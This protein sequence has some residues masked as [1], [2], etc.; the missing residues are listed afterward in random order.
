M[1]FCMDSISFFICTGVSSPFDLRGLRIHV[2]SPVLGT[3][4]N[5]AG[6][7]VFLFV[8]GRDRYNKSSRVDQGEGQQ[9]ITG[10]TN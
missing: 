7:L 10:G 3:N 4:P 6:P 1:L 5:I 2:N 9:F 8:A